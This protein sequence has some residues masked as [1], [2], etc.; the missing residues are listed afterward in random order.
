MLNSDLKTSVATDADEGPELGDLVRPSVTVI[1]PTT[2]ESSRADALRR[3]IRSVWFQQGVDL[4]LIIVV[5]GTAYDPALFAEIRRDPCLEVHYLEEPNQAAAQ[6]FGRSLVSSAFF[7]F[8]DDDD[9]YLPGALLVRIQPM[10]SDSKV[11]IVATNGF[12]FSEGRDS[13]LYT[14]P[15]RFQ[16]DFLAAVLT[17]GNWLA[18]GGA[19]FRSS[20]VPVDYFDGKTKYYEWT[21]L[22]F[23]LALDN[24]GILFIDTPTFRLH[25]TPNSLSKSDAYVRARIDLFDEMLRFNI[26]PHLLSDVKRQ[27]TRVLHGLCAYYRV[28]GDFDKAWS[29]HRSCVRS[30]YGLKYLP[31]ALLLFLRITLSR[32]SSSTPRPFK[33]LLT[34]N[35]YFAERLKRSLSPGSCE[36]ILLEP[37]GKRPLLG[38]TARGTK[39]VYQISGPSVSRKLRLFC[40]I[41]RKKI[42]LHWI[43]SDV[44]I[45]LRSGSLRSMRGDSSIVHWADAP[46]LV[47]ELRRGGI[48]A[49]FMPLFNLDNDAPV[50]F[51][52][53]PLTV[54]TYL[55][56]EKFGFYGADLVMKIAARFPDINFLV[57]GGS[58]K[59]IEPPTNVVFLGWRQDMRSIYARVHVLLRIPMHDGFSFMVAEALSHGRHV[60][61]NH[62]YPHVMTAS[63]QA[64]IEDCLKVLKALNDSGRLVSNESGRHHVLREFSAARSAGRLYEGLQLASKRRRLLSLIFRRNPTKSAG[65]LPARGDTR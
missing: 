12:L 23:R 40:A 26:P 22:A 49:Q 8:L 6:R 28:R 36:L 52:E 53:G 56:D 60:I 51:P 61:W 47:D 19:A 63:N 59:G 1:I 34:G 42:V 45:A 65:A 39:I 31:Y 21:L 29:F 30:E 54:L 37:L 24:L 13:I 58:G 32:R 57:V 7:A 33:V 20:S 27:R 46:W 9:E 55:P 2:C 5:N 35:T 17:K 25:N 38:L 4:R 18:S 3:A 48:E 62:E 43:G 50:P 10:L 11:D 64:G 16:E 44:Q 41:F 14:S 15:Q